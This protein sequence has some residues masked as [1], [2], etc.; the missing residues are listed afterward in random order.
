MTNLLFLISLG[1]GYKTN[2]LLLLLKTVCIIM[3]KYRCVGTE[4]LCNC[5]RTRIL[6]CFYLRQRYTMRVMDHDLFTLTSSCT[7]GSKA[8]SCCRPLVFFLKMWAHMKHTQ[9][10]II[11]WFTLTTVIE[12]RKLRMRNTGIY[13]VPCV[14]T[15]VNLYTVSSVS[16]LHNSSR[17]TIKCGSAI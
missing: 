11:L 7:H 2:K 16:A 13:S 9:S 14:H 15:N 1:Q 8:L 4:I 6:P 17:R 5:I 12:W 3:C 10:I